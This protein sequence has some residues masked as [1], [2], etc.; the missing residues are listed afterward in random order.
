MSERMIGDGKTDFKVY[1]PGVT[2]PP[3]VPPWERKGR[4]RRPE[5]QDE[6]ED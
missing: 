3:Y 1:P 5:V 6:A 2:P 4:P